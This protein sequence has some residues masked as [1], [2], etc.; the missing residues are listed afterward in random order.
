MSDRVFSY[1]ILRGIVGAIA[2]T[3]A[4]VTAWFSGTLL[5]S[6]SAAYHTDGQD[7]FVGALFVT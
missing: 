1:R 6:V 2:L 3:L 5:D 7:V 4:V